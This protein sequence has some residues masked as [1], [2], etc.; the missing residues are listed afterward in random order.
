MHP[1]ADDREHPQPV[2]ASRVGTAVSATLGGV[3]AALFAF[4]VA[5]HSFLL[6]DAFISFRYAR[7]L[8]DGYGLVWNIGE[9][10]EGYTNFLWVCLMAAGIRLGI[11]P[12]IFSRILSIASGAGVLR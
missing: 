9:R 11:E 12:E 6:D 5:Q 1:P 7:N 3:T 8:A 2:T 4:N 10:V